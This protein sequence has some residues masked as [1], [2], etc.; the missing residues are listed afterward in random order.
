M[1]D[2]AEKYKGW[3][4]K[5]SYIKSAVRIGGSIVSIVLAQLFGP[6]VGVVGLAI[7]LIL[8]ELLGVVEE[9]I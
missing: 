3:H 2:F 6:T 4:Q 5:I 7:A 8:A 1:S 9:W